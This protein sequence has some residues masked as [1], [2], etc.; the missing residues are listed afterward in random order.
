MHFLQF[1]IEAEKKGNP[2]VRTPSNVVHDLFMVD[3]GYR[4]CW[5]IRMLLRVSRVYVCLCVCTK[6]KKIANGCLWL[7]HNVMYTFIYVS[8]GKLCLST[9]WAAP[10]RDRE[11][12]RQRLR[13]HCLWVTLKMIVKL[14]HKN[15]SEMCFHRLNILASVTVCGYLNDT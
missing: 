10:M 12:Q 11:S 15:V 4:C 8:T 14:T 6:E 7:C 13:Q 2:T 5:V 1:H 3:A 9:F